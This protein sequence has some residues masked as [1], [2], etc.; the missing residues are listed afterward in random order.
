MKTNVLAIL[1][2]EHVLVGTNSHYIQGSSAVG[3]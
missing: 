3:P 1:D 2:R